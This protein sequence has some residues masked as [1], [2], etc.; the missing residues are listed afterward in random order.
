MRGVRAL[1]AR[2]LASS[3][4]SPGSFRSVLSYPSAS[5]KGFHKSCPPCAQTSV[6]PAALFDGLSLVYLQVGPVVALCLHKGIPQV[7]PTL[8]AILSGLLLSLMG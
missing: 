4:W 1:R 3:S 8:C 7:L 2:F 5:T 6:R